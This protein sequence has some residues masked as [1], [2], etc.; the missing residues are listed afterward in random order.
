MVQ[1]ASLNTVN[2]CE[3]MPAKTAPGH[4]PS[5]PLPTRARGKVRLYLTVYMDYSGIK[6]LTGRV[7]T[8]VSSRLRHTPCQGPKIP[9]VALNI[10]VVGGE[11]LLRGFA[12]IS[13]LRTTAD[14]VLPASTYH[15]YYV[16]V[17]PH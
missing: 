6:G 2:A 5:P 3:L 12:T 10:L 4:L 13:P 1:A 14:Q 9:V 11:S 15:P 8:Y 17:F 16:L 7:G